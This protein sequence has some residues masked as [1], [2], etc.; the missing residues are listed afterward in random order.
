M[1]ADMVRSRQRYI[2]VG[3]TNAS[4]VWKRWDIVRGHRVAVFDYSVSQQDS[5]QI[6]PAFR[7]EA[8]D[9]ACGWQ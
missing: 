9:S 8:P 7:D 5:Q 6:L 4:V 3:R 2:P 1:G